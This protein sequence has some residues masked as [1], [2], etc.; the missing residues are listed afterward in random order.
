M[1]GDWALDVGSLEES[2][3]IETLWYGVNVD[4]GYKPKARVYMG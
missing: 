3:S 2:I 1:S 4:N